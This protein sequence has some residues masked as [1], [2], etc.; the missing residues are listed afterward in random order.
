MIGADCIYCGT[1]LSNP[2]DFTS[3]IYCCDG[4]VLKDFKFVLH[5]MITKSSKLLDFFCGGFTISI[6]V[7]YWIGCRLCKK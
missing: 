1:V 4:P 7:Q 2:S 6:M 5:D 3:A